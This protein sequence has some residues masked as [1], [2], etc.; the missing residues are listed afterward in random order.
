MAVNCR[1]LNRSV[2][3]DRV[4][5]SYAV[6]SQRPCPVVGLDIRTP[7]FPSAVASHLPSG[8]IASAVTLSRWP[9][10]IRLICPVVISQTQTLPARSPVTSQVLS[11][12]IAIAVT[13]RGSLARLRSA[14]LVGW[15]EYC[16]RLRTLLSWLA[17]FDHTVF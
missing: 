12:A 16:P 15:M 9:T 2:E 1:F 5:G 4:E 3:D 11:G 6:F 7:P 17:L 8:A 13:P 10:T 14:S